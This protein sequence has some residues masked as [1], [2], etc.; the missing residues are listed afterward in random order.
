MQT[1]LVRQLT[2]EELSQNA[3]LDNID[4]DIAIAN[5]LRL[6]HAKHV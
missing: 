4:G 6:P 5:H 2:I 1:E 3:E